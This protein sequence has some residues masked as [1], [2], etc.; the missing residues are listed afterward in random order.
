MRAARLVLRWCARLALIGV[1]AS[2]A[3]VTLL[4]WVNPP[5]TSLMLIRIVEGA[6]HGELVGM[7]QR[8]VPLG[9]VSPA[10]VRAVLA[11]E[12]ARFFQHWGVDLKEL[13][14]ARAYNE[15]QNGKH[16]RGA[17]TITM[18]CA[19]SVFLWPGRTWIRK[20]IE[21]WLAVLMEQLWG[22][23]RILEVYL[24]VVEWGRGIYGAE[25]AALRHFAVP[26][27][28]LDGSRAALLAAALP[29]PLR[30][31]PGTPSAALRRRA[32][33]IAAR[34]SGIELPGPPRAR[35]H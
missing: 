16:L 25:A 12:D 30:F 14:S 11:G 7:D 27:S 29:S 26:A 9:E 18:Q 24:N 4:H 17:S 31:D 3:L 33:I 5:V 22:K 8:W 15:R 23:R 1:A 19:R 13:E 35:S 6:L 28:S 2:F 34:A 20:G 32:A 10:L 21:V